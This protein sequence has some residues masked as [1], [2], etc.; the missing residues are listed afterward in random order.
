MTSVPVVCFSI[1]SNGRGSASDVIKSLGSILVRYPQDADRFQTGCIEV[2]VG[3]VA[4]SE[5]KLVDI[6]STS[7]KPIICIRRIVVFISHGLIGILN[8][9]S[10]SFITVFGDPC[11]A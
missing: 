11:L 6:D 3:V 10:W 4:A 9:E 1:K 5:L 2:I 8:A 7:L